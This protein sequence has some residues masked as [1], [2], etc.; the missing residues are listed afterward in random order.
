MTLPGEAE[1]AH[2]FDEL[3]QAAQI[4][5]PVVAGEF[6]QQDRIRLAPDEAIDGGAE[7][8]VVARQLDHRA[9]DQFDRGGPQL[10]DVLRRVH[11]L[12]EGGEMADA[13]HPMRR[14]RLKIEL[15][16]TEKANVP[17]EPTSRC[18]ML[19]PASSIMSML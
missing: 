6:G 19:W 10:D 3:F 12:V 8:R 4:V 16:L 5:V 11:R 2:Q 18:A 1:I 9:I 7:H 17:S 14:Y 15:Y 13:E